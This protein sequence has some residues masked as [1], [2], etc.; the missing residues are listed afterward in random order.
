MA[1]WLGL[2]GGLI[3][4]LVAVG[5]VESTKGVCRSDGGNA[6]GTA[7]GDVR[8]VVPSVEFFEGFSDETI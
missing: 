5:D 3:W 8:N 4:G 2:P 7:S 1:E 6:V